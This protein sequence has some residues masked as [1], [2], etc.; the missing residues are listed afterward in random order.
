MEEQTSFDYRGCIVTIALVVINIIIYIYC[1]YAGE[2][3][4]NIGCM[5]AERVLLD[6]E[7]Y[8]FFTSMFMHGGIDHIFSNMIFLA[9]LGE[10][11]ERVIGHVRF[12][13][14]YLLSGVGGSLFSIANVVLSGNHYTAIGASG[15][16]FGLIGAMIILV[17]INNGHYQGISIRRM[18]F[19]IA[20]MVYSGMRSN[21]VDNAAHIGGLISGV[22]IM[23]VMYVIETFKP[24]NGRRIR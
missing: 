10:M 1:T 13:I 6:G 8:R 9:A 14:L 5:D 17:V 16:V 4:Y 12:A 18:L 11:L 7:Y 15:A 19:A 21:N 20:Y 23:A 2:V 22:L 3:V 24:R